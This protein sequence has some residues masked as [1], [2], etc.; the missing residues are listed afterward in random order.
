MHE[1][2][3]KRNQDDRYKILLNSLIRIKVL[4]PVCKHIQ[5]FAIYYCLSGDVLTSLHLHTM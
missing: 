1:V 3:L 2:Y 5:D 4:Y